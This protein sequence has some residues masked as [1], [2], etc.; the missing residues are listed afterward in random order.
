VLAPQK[1]QPTSPSATLS[2]HHPVGRTRDGLSVKQRS[3]QGPGSQGKQSLQEKRLLVRVLWPVERRFD[4]LKRN[5]FVLRPDIR[6]AAGHSFCALRAF[7]AR[8]AL[9][10]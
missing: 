3:R 8:R 5:H 9:W 7:A 4:H 2:I 1:G 6:S 10:K